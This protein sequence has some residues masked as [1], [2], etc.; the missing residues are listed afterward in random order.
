MSP[1]VPVVRARASSAASTP[2]RA[3]ARRARSCRGHA[4]T[5]PACP[6]GRQHNA[7]HATGRSA[8]VTAMT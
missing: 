3:L 4:C 2:L 1:K 6:A 8:P 7:S 5:H